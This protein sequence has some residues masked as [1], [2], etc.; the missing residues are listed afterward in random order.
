M[1]VSLRGVK[2]ATRRYRGGLRASL[3]PSTLKAAAHGVSPNRQKFRDL[4]AG[5][6][7]GIGNNRTEIR[8]SLPGAMEQGT[9]L[10]ADSQPSFPAPPGVPALLRIGRMIDTSPPNGNCV[11]TKC[12]H[13]E[14]IKINNLQNVFTYVNGCFPG[15]A[16]LLD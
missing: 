9:G 2:A 11:R 8:L 10:R 12:L 16:D 14:S 4:W 7:S 3:D 15:K 6:L 1:V 13:M 5:A